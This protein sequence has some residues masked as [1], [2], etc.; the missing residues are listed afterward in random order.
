MCFSFN[1]KVQYEICTDY[2]MNLS[3]A[4]VTV[5]KCEVRW[6]LIM[7]CCY[8]CVTDNHKKLY[9]LKLRL[10][11]DSQLIYKFGKFYD[12][13]FVWASCNILSLC[14]TD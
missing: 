8:C 10:S 13:G 6:M 4:S 12:S 5:D 1:S 11:F 7:L 2:E 3:G 9:I 14:I